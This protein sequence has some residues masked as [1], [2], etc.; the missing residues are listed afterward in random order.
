MKW[1]VDGFV[2][3][4]CVV[5]VLFVVDLIG[6]MFGLYFVECVLISFVEV[7][8]SDVVCFN[9]FFYLMFDEGV[10]FVLFVYEV[11]FVLSMYDDVVIDVMFVAVCCVFVVFVV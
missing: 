4:V 9:C 10:Y 5:G 2:V 1:F 11:G 3:E 7:M 6:V 8:K